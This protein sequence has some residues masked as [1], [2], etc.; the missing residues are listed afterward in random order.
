MCKS[1][2]FV[3]AADRAV[4]SATANIEQAKQLVDLP[5]ISTAVVQ[6]MRSGIYL[7]LIG[8]A[9]SQCAAPL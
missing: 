1:Q 4:Q 5:Q 3:Q 9:L 6:S 8:G 7:N 2:F